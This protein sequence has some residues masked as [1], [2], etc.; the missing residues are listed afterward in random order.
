MGRPQWADLGMYLQTV[1]VLLRAEGLDSCPQ[2][3]WSHTTVDK[4]LS[5][6]A[7]QM[8]FCG[9]PS[10][11]RTTRLGHRGPLVHPTI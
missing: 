9:C 7:E 8:L 5:P 11:M 3:A 1:M 6:P 10:V 2:I 4:V